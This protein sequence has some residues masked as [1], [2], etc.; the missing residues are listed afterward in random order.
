M[1]VEVRKSANHDSKRIAGEGTGG[2]CPQP[3]V[4]G[5]DIRSADYEVISALNSL[6]SQVAET[7]H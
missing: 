3:L 7:K 6:L 2:I 1:R 5:Q 4:R